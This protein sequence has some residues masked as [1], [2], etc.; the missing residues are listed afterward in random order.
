MQSRHRFYALIAAILLALA[1]GAVWHHA[2]AAADDDDRPPI[3]VRSGSIKFDGG[4]ASQANDPKKCCRNWK[5]DF[6]GEQWKPEE[7]AGDVKRFEVTVAAS[8]CP[9]AAMTGVTAEVD[10][11]EKGQTNTFTFYIEPFWLF[12]TDEPKLDS[13]VK[14]H[15]TKAANAPPPRRGSSAPG[16]LDYGTPGQGSITRVKVG[17]ATCN[18]TGPAVITLQP[19][20]AP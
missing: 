3:I 2:W 4:D 19:K 12:G 20:K 5:R 16:V 1:G 9:A 14:L 18:P 6:F 15:N 8:G 10:Y 11:T 13:P 7:S 17:T